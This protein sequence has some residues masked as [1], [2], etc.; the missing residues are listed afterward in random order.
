MESLVQDLRFALRMLRRSPGVTAIAV[1]SLG[2]GIGANT[3]IASL[4]DAVFLR[5]LPVEQPARLAWIYRTF[6]Q[7]ATGQGFFGAGLLP[8]SYPNY[9]DFEE[10]SASFQGMLA[11]SGGGLALSGAGGEPEQIAAG[12]VTANYFDVL[13]VRPALGRGFEPGDNLRGGGRPV[14][15]ISD[16]L[17]R[18]RFGADRGIVGGDITLNGRAFTVIG[19]TPPEYH[20]LLTLFEE[21]LWIPSE[22]WP[23]L[24]TG[25]MAVALEHRGFRMFWMVGRLRAGVSH[26]AAELEL[27][28]I[29]E[30]L[31]VEHPD[32]NRDRGVR[33]ASLSEGALNLNQRGM[34]VRAG[35]IGSAAVG[36]VLLIACVNVGSLLTARARARAGE[37]ALR[38]SLGAPRRRLLRQWLTESVVLGLLGGVAGWLIA[39]WTKPLLLR[40]RPPFLEDFDVPL[41]LRLLAFTAAIS[42]AAG[43]LFG[44][45]PA[46]RAARTDLIGQIGERGRLAAM[47]R[48][49]GLRRALVVGQVALS[50]VALCVAGLFLRSLEEARAID[51]GFDVERLAIVGLDVGALGTG[52]EEGRIFFD[53]LIEEARSLPEVSE[54][55]LAQAQPLGFVGE[56]RVF[57][58]GA[59]ELVGSEGVYTAVNPV[60]PGF[61]A[62]IGI[63]LREGRLFDGRDRADGLPV[64]IVNETAARAYWPDG[65]IGRT[66][67][68]PVHERPWEIVGV[69]AD[70]KYTTL[71][72]EPQ[73]YVYRPLAQDY[74]GAV[75]LHL[76]AETDPSAALAAV[77]GRIRP[78][79]PDLPLL[80]PQPVAA[81]IDQSLW[82]PAFGAR[83]LSTFG[84]LALLLAGVGIYGVVSQSVAERRREVGIRMAL[85]AGRSRVLSGVLRDGMTPVGAGVAL[86]LAVAFVLVRQF[87]ALL[88]QQGV[89]APV[90]ALAA[91]VL[92]LTALAA[93]VVPAA[94]ALR[95]DPVRTLRSE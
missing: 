86:G 58:E 81:V 48:R 11:A 59:E 30:Q 8:A 10:R 37:T 72:E 28:S 67:R 20:G 18:G 24:T 19:V 70:I 80:D 84:L 47:A 40:V 87:H 21:D 94:R 33:V 66:I 64:A 61:F 12:F 74:T 75:V 3:A 9:L 92:V 49:V 15:V 35:A 32:M 27:A 44:L 7:S 63:E 83:L 73:P 62:T 65:A 85:G 90:F 88:Y 93:C 39:V 5:P 69:V 36:L 43:L 77:T 16:A 46:L 22:L 60:T 54:A 1:L 45:A 17:W 13:G 57:P 41:D 51:P 26:A 78:L 68:W 23:E 95:V 34:F 50:A 89:D 55:A 91:L 76:R 31:A 53:R 52:P 71:G 25:P 82:A 6:E 4:V 38:L 56:R 2:I 42:L 14:A 29:A 79:A